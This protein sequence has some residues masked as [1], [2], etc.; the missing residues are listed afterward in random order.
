MN[1]ASASVAKQEKLIAFIL[2]RSIDISLFFLIAVVPLV[3]TPY[4]LDYW[5]R[6][7]V[8]CIFGLLLVIGASV[9]IKR[10]G[11]KE[12]FGLKGNPLL[13][14]LLAYGISAVL[15]TIFSIAPEISISGDLFREEGIFTILSYICLTIFFSMLVP[16][17]QHAQALIKWLLISGALISLY[18]MLQYFG[19]NPT[20]H[21][22]HFMR[23]REG[24]V[25]STMGNPIFWEN[26]WFS[27][28][29]FSWHFTL[30]PLR[31]GKKFCCWQEAP[32]RLPHSL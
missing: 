6:P 2:Q 31:K 32:L 21:F 12:H 27:C 8:D 1:K 15:S 9:A 19:Y 4:G 23:H 24:R 17:Q 18:A 20:E 13:I 28:S 16:S 7:K 11:L 14:P 22:L 5:Y 10:L 30:T 29:L 3:V 26:F 25:G